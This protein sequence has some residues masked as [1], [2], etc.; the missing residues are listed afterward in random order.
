M[1]EDE[2]KRE[3]RRKEEEE[4]EGGREEEGSRED[5][6]AGKDPEEKK[7]ESRGRRQPKIWSFDCPW[8]SKQNE[9]WDH[10]A[11]TCAH[12]A[13][14]P[15]KEPDDGLQRRLGWPSEKNRAYDE[16]VIDW[17][18]EARAAMIQRRKSG[19]SRR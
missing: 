3:L 4:E 12:R 16:Q 18:A 17:L 9:D 15:Q 19:G 10:A 2:K 6:E 7:E 8:C 5:E 13:G 1:V 11:W 14:G